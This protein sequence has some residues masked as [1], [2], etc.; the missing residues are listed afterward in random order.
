M[1]NS[2]FFFLISLEAMQ[3]SGVEDN[4]ISLQIDRGQAKIIHWILLC[5]LKPDI[6]VTKFVHLVFAFAKLLMMKL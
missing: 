4:P 6:W 5:A 3:G 2:C 1:V